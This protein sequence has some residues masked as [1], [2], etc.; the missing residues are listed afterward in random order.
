MFF[1]LTASLLKSYSGVMSNNSPLLLSLHRTLAHSTLLTRAAVCSAVSPRA[2]HAVA[3]SWRWR[4]SATIAAWPHSRATSMTVLPWLSRLLS[5][6]LTTLLGLERVG[7]ARDEKMTR[8]AR[9]QPLP[10]VQHGFQAGRVAKLGGVVR[11]AASY[12]S[13]RTENGRT[14]LGQQAA[15]VRLRVRR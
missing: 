14:S 4:S 5:S 8:S 1:T 9:Q 15:N 13:P 2:L 7:E 10:G 3:N 12:P 6:A 11:G